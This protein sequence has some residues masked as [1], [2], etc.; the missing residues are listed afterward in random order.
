MPRR[1]PAPRP[2]PV[3]E[4]PVLYTVGEH[5]LSLRVVPGGRWSVSLDGG[6]PAEQT[7]VTQVEA[8][9]AGVRTAHAQDLLRRP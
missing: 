2:E 4:A 7:F 9:E 8:W 6:A 5:A 1:K 3:I